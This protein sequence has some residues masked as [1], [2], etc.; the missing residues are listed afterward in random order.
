MM[1]D[2]GYRLGFSAGDITTLRLLVQEHLLLS[3]AAT[4]RDPDDPATVRTVVDAVGSHEVLDLLHALT[5][6]DSLATGPAAWSDWKARLITTLVDRVHATIAGTPAKETPSLAAAYREILG[7]AGVQVSVARE[8]DGLRVLVAADD[9]VGLLSTVAGALATQRLD[10]L[11]AT[12][13]TQGE[14]ALQSWLTEPAFGEAP[15]AEVI[16]SAIRRALEADL[17]LA[18][19]LA[20][21]RAMRPTRR[22]FTPPPPRV[23]ML[24]A[25][26]DRADV[27]EVRAHDQPALLWRVTSALAEAH[28]SVVNALVATLGSEVIDVLYLVESDG[29]RLQAHRIVDAIAAVEAALQVG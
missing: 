24:D 4:R 20:S 8:T 18:K 22:G 17:D 2:I 3:E 5:E 27:L 21:L 11:S 14:R 25:A 29:S 6:A 23:R 19:G 12:V 1:Q 28:F 10:V 26:S 16:T 15:D 9:R 13:D 7:A